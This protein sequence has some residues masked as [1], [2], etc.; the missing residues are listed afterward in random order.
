[1][2]RVRGNHNYT[3]YNNFFTEQENRKLYSGSRIA[4]GF[5][6]NEELTNEFVF[7]GTME[8]AMDLD[9]YINW[10]SELPTF[11]PKIKYEDSKI[12]LYFE[13]NNWSDSNYFIAYENTRIPQTYTFNNSNSQNETYFYVERDDVISMRYLVHTENGMKTLTTRYVNIN[14]LINLEENIEIK[15]TL[16]IEQGNFDVIN[17]I[18]NNIKKAFV[19]IKEVLFYFWSKCNI[20]I[21]Q[22]IIWVLSLS[23]FVSIFKMIVV[24]GKRG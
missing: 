15:E 16:D 9:I 23:L 21:K 10:T 2:S 12:K 20:K 14:D 13:F 3:N 22:M 18:F 7:D 5:Y 4:L 17:N 24:I 19:E 11:T 6:T 8:P 1:M